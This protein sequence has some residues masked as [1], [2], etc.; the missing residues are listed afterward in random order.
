MLTATDITVRAGFSGLGDSARVAHVENETLVKA[1]DHIK[2]LLE[3]CSC[4]ILFSF[5]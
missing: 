1:Q 2:H 5:T 3:V 4:D